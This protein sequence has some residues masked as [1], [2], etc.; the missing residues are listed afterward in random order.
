[1]DSRTGVQLRPY[2]FFCSNAPRANEEIAQEDLVSSESRRFRKM[3]CFTHLV[4]T[5]W[6]DMGPSSTPARGLWLVCIVSMLATASVE[7]KPATIKVR[8]RSF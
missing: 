6:T 4:D 1:M 5:A 2:N 3:T 8:G 7:G